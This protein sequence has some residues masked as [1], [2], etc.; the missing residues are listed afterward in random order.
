MFCG[1]SAAPVLHPPARPPAAAEE[2]A[3]GEDHSSLR[4]PGGAERPE[5]AGQAHAAA[6][7]AAQG[8][9]HARF[10]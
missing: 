7:E 3:G 4:T 10:S 6:D 9:A 1:R 2:A 5:A 8:R